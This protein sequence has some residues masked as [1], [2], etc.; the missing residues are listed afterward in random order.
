MLGFHTAV[1]GGGVAAAFE[2]MRPAAMKVLEARMR[3]IGQVELLLA[4]LGPQAGAV[5]AALY[6][7][8]DAKLDGRPEGRF[9]SGPTG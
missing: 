5:G 1:I 3:L 8:V 4:E 9:D 2:L 6:V 7:A